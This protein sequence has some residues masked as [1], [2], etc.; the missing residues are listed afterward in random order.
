MEYNEKLSLNIK[1][2]LEQEFDRPLLAELHG[3]STTVNLQIVLNT[4][5]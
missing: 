3:R 5:K 1:T 4:P 2:T